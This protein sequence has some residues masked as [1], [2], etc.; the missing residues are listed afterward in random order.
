MKFLKQSKPGLLYLLTAFLFVNSLWGKVPCEDEFKVEKKKNYSKSYPLSGN[1]LVKLDN[2]FGEMKIIT[3]DKSEAKVEVNI[4]VKANSEQGAQKLLDEIK[5]EDGKEGNTVYFKT[6][7]GFKNKN[8]KKNDDDDDDD[9]EDNEKNYKNSNNTTSMEIN[10]TVYMPAGNP[11]NAVNSFGSMVV[12]DLTGEAEIASRFGSLTCGKLNNNKE[13]SVEFGK[14]E[15][16]RI[17]GGEVN[18]K[19]SRAGIGKISG[20]IK[21]NFE[22]SKATTINL[23]NTL[24]GLRVY[25]SYSTV[26][27]VLSKDL[28]AEFEVK[29]NF[30]SFKNNSNAKI[31]EEKE[32]D[33]DHGPKFDHTYSGKIGSGAIKIKIKSSFGTVKIN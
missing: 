1:T 23:D 3:W 22:F 9:N 20:D 32:E 7:V 26:E 30:G 19:F 24:K 31:T 12:P 17:N 10:M 29:T 16:E 6:S 27:L 33:D 4:T 21:A 8:W 28:S 11:I 15:I 5:F 13:V 14:G 18:I 2:S 25:N